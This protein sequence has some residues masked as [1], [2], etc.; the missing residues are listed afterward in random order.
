[1]KIRTPPGQC[2]VCKPNGDVIIRAVD[3]TTLKAIQRMRRFVDAWLD[4]QK[5][6]K[7]D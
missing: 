2:Q 5:E 3:T 4:E 1:M 7:D 6:N